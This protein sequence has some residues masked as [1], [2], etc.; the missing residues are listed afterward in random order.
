[1]TTAKPLIDLFML[2]WNR[3]EYTD[4]TLK[5]LALVPVGVPWDKV[6]FTVIDQGST[7]DN[8]KIIEASP[9][10][11]KLIKLDKNLGV[12]GGM[13]Y[14]RQYC[15][16]GAPYIGKIDNDS[17]FTAFWLRKLL[18]ALED[19]KDDGLGLVGAKQGPGVKGEPVVGAR[20]AG[21]YPASIVGG[22]FLC[23]R[24]AFINGKMPGKGLFGWQPFQRKVISKTYKIGWCH[25]PAVI[26]HVG[27]WAMKHPQAITNDKYVEY[28][29]KVGRYKG[30]A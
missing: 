28:M 14:F 6:R 16:S 27:D 23:L 1:M 4:M 17:L 11:D 25:P 19:C 22:R 20:G 15:T 3:C 24:D 30:E 9:L 21:Y 13:D 12:A 8:V 5:S 18:W 10:V 26:E 7:D 29:K 2:T